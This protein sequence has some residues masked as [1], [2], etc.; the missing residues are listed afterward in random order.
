MINQDQNIAAVYAFQ[1]VA[2]IKSVG[3]VIVLQA[4]VLYYDIQD[5]SVLFNEVADVRIDTTKG[6]N[7]SIP[8]LS[9]DSRCFCEFSTKYQQF[10]YNGGVLTITGTSNGQKHAYKV[11]IM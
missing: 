4:S 7:V 8:A 11:T 1:N 10:T 5:K 2:K 9:W 3:A 6:S